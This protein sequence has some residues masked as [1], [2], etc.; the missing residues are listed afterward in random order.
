MLIAVFL[1]KVDTNETGK[2][3]IAIAR[4]EVR[5]S[6]YRKRERDCSQE[7]AI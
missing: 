4:S 1:K 5:F 3:E 2:K 6:G 7:K